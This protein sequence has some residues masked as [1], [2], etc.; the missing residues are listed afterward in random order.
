MRDSKKNR[1]VDET[2]AIGANRSAG[3]LKQQLRDCRAAG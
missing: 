3:L 2:P 1:I